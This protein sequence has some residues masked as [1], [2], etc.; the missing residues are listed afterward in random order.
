[1]GCI[2][3]V[4]SA[5]TFTAQAAEHRGIVTRRGATLVTFYWVVIG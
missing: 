3:G 2:Q 5:T 1:M 4:G